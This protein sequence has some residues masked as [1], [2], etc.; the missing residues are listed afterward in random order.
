MT[1][2]AGVL[3]PREQDIYTLD[4]TPL[5]NAGETLTSIVS[6]AVTVIRG[7]DPNPSAFL[8][9]TPAPAINQ[10]SVTVKTQAISNGLQQTATIAAGCCI[11]GPMGG[12]VDGAW[13]EIAG[14]AQTSNTLR[15]LVC[16]IIVP[17]S[18][19]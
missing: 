12:G 13:Y 4:F 2:T 1:T 16:K 9:A 18:A 19:S 7:I 15:R 17:V 6:V 3:D 8:P 11:Q 10:A 5:L 14:E